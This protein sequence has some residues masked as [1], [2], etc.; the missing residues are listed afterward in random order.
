MGVLNTENSHSNYI[1]QLATELQST[2]RTPLPPAKPSHVHHVQAQAQAQCKP[3]RPAAH[4][5]PHLQACAHRQ[6]PHPPHPP[7]VYRASAYARLRVGSGGAP[8]WP[9]LHALSKIPEHI[10]SRIC[11]YGRVGE[12]VRTG[13]QMPSVFGLWIT[14]SAK[15][16]MN[17]TLPIIS[18]YSS[19]AL[20]LVSPE[21]A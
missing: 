11:P 9:N 2:L 14:S 7:C 20:T 12:Y 10:R 3:Q 19:H 15:N 5:Q 18:A 6:M 1:S 13:R 16:V 4:R 8:R 17:G 21:V